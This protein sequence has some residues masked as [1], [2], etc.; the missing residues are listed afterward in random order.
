MSEFKNKSNCTV[1]EERAKWPWYVHSSR[2]NNN[3]CNV[4][5]YCDGE[6]SS[7]SSSSSSSPHSD[8]FHHTSESKPPTQKTPSSCPHTLI[9]AAGTLEGRATGTY[10]SFIAGC[11]G[12]PPC[13]VSAVWAWGQSLICDVWKLMLCWPDNVPSW[14]PAK[15]GVLAAAL[16]WDIKGWA[17]SNIIDLCLVHHSKKCFVLHSRALHEIMHPALWFRC[18]CSNVLI[19]ARMNEC[20]IM[21][22]YYHHYYYYS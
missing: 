16:W 14:I 4:Q 6:C 11:G 8:L 21:E 2:F 13:H 3:M 5:E 18:Y 7:S 19:T 17:A 1:V 20:V 15:S 9:R 22:Y 10:S 12:V